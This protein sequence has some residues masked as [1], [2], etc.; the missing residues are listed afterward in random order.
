[1]IGFFLLVMFIFVS[2]GL[3]WNEEG[4]EGFYDEQAINKAKNNRKLWYND[5]HGNR[6][7][8]STH[9]KVTVWANY[10]GKI[11]QGHTYLKG[12][13]WRNIIDLTEFQERGYMN[14]GFVVINDA[15]WKQYLIICEESER[16]RR[17]FK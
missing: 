8:I 4:K 7:L 6:R 1:M 16:K 5:Y 17:R 2:I 10:A 12:S 3:K 13:D 11:Q 15:V 9:E 14:R